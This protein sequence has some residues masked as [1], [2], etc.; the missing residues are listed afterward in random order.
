MAGWKHFGLVL[1]LAGQLDCGSALL[2][3]SESIWWGCSEVILGPIISF[4][5]LILMWINCDH[6]FFLLAQ[7]FIRIV[8]DCIKLDCIKV[9]QDSSC[10]C[11][12]KAHE[13]QEGGIKIYTFHRGRLEGKSHSFALSW[14]CCMPSCPTLPGLPSCNRCRSHHSA[15]G[16]PVKRLE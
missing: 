14:H 4:Q 3:C 13:S 15:K 16:M 12:R 1:S 7:L 9:H 2:I 6:S 11:C 10:C 5:P 8:P